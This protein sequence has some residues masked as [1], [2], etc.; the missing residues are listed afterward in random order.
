MPRWESLMALPGH[1]R[2]WKPQTFRSW[3]GTSERLRGRI[4]GG[5]GFFARPKNQ[6]LTNRFRDKHKVFM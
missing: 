2:G 3:P 5:C 4:C 6:Q 1:P